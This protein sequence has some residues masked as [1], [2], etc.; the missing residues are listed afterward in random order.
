MKAILLL[1]LPIIFS[2]ASSAYNTVNINYNGHVII[3]DTQSKELYIPPNARNLSINVKYVIENNTIILSSIP[4]TISYY[5]NFSGVISFSENFTSKIII[6]LPS[7][8]K[9]S[10]ISMSPISFKYYNDYFNLTFISK[11]ITIL[12]YVSGY[13]Y[14]TEVSH[15][16]ISIF[17]IGFLV[18]LF[19]TTFLLFL[20]IKRNRVNINFEENTNTLDDRDKKI[21]EAIKNG[22]DNL[23][24]ISEMTQLPRT[25]VYRRVKRL[26]SLGYL[27]EIREK[28]KVKYLVKGDKNEQ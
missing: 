27:A 22:A 26:K 15:N 11:N 6:I 3:Y 25:T 12:Y 10:Y 5:E 16:K 23:T 9:L 7:Y 1:I 18:S 19:S 24:R 8:I 28:G 14:T 13:T 17:F 4:A 20:L 21:I 2:L